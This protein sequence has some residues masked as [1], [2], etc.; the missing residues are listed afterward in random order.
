[1]SDST[2]MHTQENV[3]LVDEN[4][5]A[6]GTAEKLDA[7]LAGSL[8]RA[9][10]VVV[11]SSQGDLLLQQRAG[12]KYHSGG[13]WSNTCCG[14]PRPGE[15]TISAAQRRLR[16]EMGISCTL[17]FCAAFV[18]RAEVDESLIEHEYDQVLLGV[19]DGEPLPDPSE[20]MAWRWS[21]AHSVAVGIASQPE[22]YTAWLPLVLAHALGRTFQLD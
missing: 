13:L 8:H 20:V 3:V 14:H 17:A 7:H 19:Y 22:R 16:E 10:S 15:D 2:V 21:D 6:I 4:N 5:V 9:F 1:M 18:Y 11:V 12:A